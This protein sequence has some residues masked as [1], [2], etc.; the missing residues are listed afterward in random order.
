VAVILEPIASPRAISTMLNR[1][2][3][4]VVP[5]GYAPE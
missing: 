2:P 3:N 1:C 4:I 5:P